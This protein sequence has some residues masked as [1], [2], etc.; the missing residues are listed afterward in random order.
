MTPDA[1]HHIFVLSILALATILLVV[2]MRSFAGRRHART[3]AQ[4]S[5]A[6]LEALRGDVGEMKTRLAAVETLLREVG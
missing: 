6:A 2:A 1:A 3:A 4:P 5:A